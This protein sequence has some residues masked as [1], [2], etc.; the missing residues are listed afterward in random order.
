VTEMQFEKASVIDATGLI[1]GRMSSNVAKRLLSGETIVIL[2]AEKAIIS[3][4][5]QSKVI[6]AKTFLEV[7]HPGKGPYH[8]RRPDTMIRKT[9]RGML[10]KRKPKGLEALKRLRVFLGVPEEFEGKQME[11]ITNASSQK[12]KCPYLTVGQ[13]AKEI[14][15]NPV[16]E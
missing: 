7:G 5:R 16:G 2:N 13:L 9:V 1:L 4:T 12:L 15:W 10:P 11:T 14:G 6:Q 8:R 3:G